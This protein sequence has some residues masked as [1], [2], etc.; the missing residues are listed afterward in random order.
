M[1][2]GGCFYPQRSI[3]QHL[4]ARGAGKKLKKRAKRVKKLGKQKLLKK[5]F[6]FGRKVCV[7]IALDIKFT[8]KM[9]NKKK[10]RADGVGRRCKKGVGVKPEM[11][12]SLCLPSKRSAFDGNLEIGFV[13]SL[14]EFPLISDLKPKRTTIN[15]ARN[16]NCFHR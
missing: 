14:Y 6:E 16:S 11:V 7:G 1:L 10:T 2:A 8:F 3:L 9:A 4:R 12:I 13:S 15:I 5:G